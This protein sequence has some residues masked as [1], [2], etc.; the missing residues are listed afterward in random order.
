MPVGKVKWYDEDK[1]FGFASNPGYEDVYL[2]SHVLPEGVEELHKGQRIEF[3]VASGRRGPQ[4]LR[5][6]L[7]DPPKVRRHRRSA[8]ELGSMVSDLITLLEGV[9]PGLRSGRY[10]ERRTGWQ[11]A[12]ILRAV[13]DELD[14]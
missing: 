10:P 4:A 1:G 6:A 14:G 3:D 9:Q 7:L 8:E 5:V 13:A 12:G 2:S 11:V